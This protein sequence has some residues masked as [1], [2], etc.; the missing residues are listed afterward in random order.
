MSA[1]MRLMKVMSR[2]S[3]GKRAPKPAVEAAKDKRRWNIVFGDRVQVVGLHPDKGKQGKVLKVL[4]KTDR[5]VVE[6]INVTNSNVKGNSDRGIPGR[7]VKREASIPYSAVNLVDPVTNGPTRISYSF[8]EDGTKVRVAK[9]SGAVIP[10][11][12]ALRLRSK[13]KRS[14]V[15]DS[16]TPAEDVWEITYED[17][18]TTA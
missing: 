16:D 17:F 12:D 11:P 4:R 6:G 15:T 7:V 8:L 5:I 3:P 1:R 18:Q 14:L 13:P 2:P 9:K 10:K